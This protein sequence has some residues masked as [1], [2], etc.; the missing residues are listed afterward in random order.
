MEALSLCSWTPPVFPFRRAIKT[1]TGHEFTVKGC[2]DR[3]GD[4]APLSSAS[5]AF[6]VLGIQP[7]CSA[8]ELKAAFRAKV[9]IF[10]FLKAQES[11]ISS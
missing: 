1:R 6:A 2:S 4:D 11:I 5:S 10:R 9:I 3:T 7:T 8:A